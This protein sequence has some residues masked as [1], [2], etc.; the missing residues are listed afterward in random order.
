MVRPLI[1]DGLVTR[2]FP[3]QGAS[4]YAKTSVKGLCLPCNRVEAACDLRYL[5][6]SRHVEPTLVNTEVQIT[7]AG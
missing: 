6:P 2:P 3:Y 1:P 4:S 5:V 7:F